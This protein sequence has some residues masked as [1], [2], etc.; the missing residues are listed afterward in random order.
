MKDGVMQNL[1]DFVVETGYEDLPEAV[2][3][4]SKRVLLDSIGV[5]IAGLATDKG[6]YA[7]ELARRFGGSPEAII[8]GIGDRVSCNSAAFANGELINALD[9]DALLVPSHISPC[10]IPALLALAEINSAS[11]RDLLVAN[12]LAHEIS[13]RFGRA[14]TSIGYATLYGLNLS[15]VGGTAGAAKVS[16]LDKEKMTH[17]LSLACYMAPSLIPMM[18]FPYAAPP[19][20][21]KYVPAG[22]VA[23]TEIIAVLLAEMGYIGDREIFDGE[24]AFWEAMHQAQWDPQRLTDSLG[25]RWS[26]LATHYKPYPCCRLMHSGLDG[27]IK[28]I[29]DNNLCAEDIEQVNVFLNP[30][31]DSPV[32]TNRQIQSCIDAQFSIAY[33]FAAAAHRVRIGADWQD[34]Q[35]ISNPKIVEFM[36]KV[37]FYPHP[38]FKSVFLENPRTDLS[39]VEVAAKGQL[40]RQETTFAKGTHSPLEFRMTDEEL[41]NKFKSNTSRNLPR[42]KINQAIKYLFELDNKEN[43]VELMEL[44]TM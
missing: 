26:F 15:V 31:S 19:S 16:K 44:V 14:L 6:K 41:E 1:V 9:M 5:A 21:A 25:E 32:W 22:L 37:S 11:G 8:L 28:I 24:H 34:A 4:E 39:L 20:M 38:E 23:Q 12:V 42:N 30:D 43:V 18:R 29:E 36:D 7:V 33:V 27:F 13:T 10:V 35:T 3:H 17:A 40:F 2:V